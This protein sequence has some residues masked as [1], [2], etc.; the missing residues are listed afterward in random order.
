MGTIWPRMTT[1]K[2][3]RT[4]EWFIPFF[5]HPFPPFGHLNR[6]WR[7]IVRLVLAGTAGAISVPATA[8]R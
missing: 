4:F 5:R 1:K 2:T 7:I 3:T 6:I 8:G